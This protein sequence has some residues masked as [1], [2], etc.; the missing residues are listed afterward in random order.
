MV[1]LQSTSIQ[2]IGDSGGKRLVVF[3]YPEPEIG[4]MTFGIQSIEKTEKFA[5]NN[6]TNITNI[7]ESGLP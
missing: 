1:G 7:H 5:A 3:R 6:A 4:L 2:I